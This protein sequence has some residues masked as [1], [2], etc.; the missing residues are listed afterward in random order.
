MTLEDI[1]KYI[2][3]NPTPTII[4]F[5]LIPVVAA[6]VAWI[7]A[8]EGTKKPWGY[9]YSTI[10]YLVAIPGIFAL[11][12]CI[13]Q[14]LFKRDFDFTQVNVFVYFLPIISM[15]ATFLILRRVVELDKI[16]G[17][18][19]LSGLLMTIAATIVFMFILDFIIDK[20]K[21][22]AFVFIKAPFTILLGIF[23][24]LFFLFRFG[25]KKLFKG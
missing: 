12:L 3:D 9:I 5:L 21:I 6:I 10:I 8:G 1:F 18:D 23:V 15:V 22:Y 17:Y 19:K 24:V 20:T 11:T 13:Y 4:F 7:G 14:F 2:G 25:M 16:P